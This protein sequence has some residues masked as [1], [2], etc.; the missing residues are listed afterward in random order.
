M[1]RKIESLLKESSL[2]ETKNGEVASHSY[3][4]KNQRERLKNICEMSLEKFTGDILEIGAHIGLTTKI[5]CELARKHN[6][7]VYVIDPW[8]GEQQGGSGEYNKF[9]I[10]TKGYEDVLVLKKQSSLTEESR[11]IIR[12]NNFAFCFVDGLHTRDACRYDIESCINQKGI[13]AVDDLTW[14]PGL[15]DLVFEFSEKYKRKNVVNNKIREGYI[16]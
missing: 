12:E 3:G 15:K 2:T 6:R 13:I 5:F 8:N 14:S 4:S 9:M 11:N 16:I 7:K 1:K 10:N